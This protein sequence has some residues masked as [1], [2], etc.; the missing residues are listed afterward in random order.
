MIKNI[1]IVG[2]MGHVGFATALGLSKKYNVIGCYN[3]NINKKKQKLLKKNN[4]EI[5]KINLKNKKKISQFLKRR[6]I[7]KII[8]CAGVS[9][10]IYAKKDPSKTIES[11]VSNV[12]NIFEILKKIKK[13]QFLYI[14]TGSVFQ[15]IKSE[16]I[17]IYEDTVP[18]P[19][20]IYSGSKRMGEIIVESYRKYFRV[21]CSILRISW[22]YGPEEIPKKLNIQRGPIPFIINRIL[23]KKGKTINIATGGQFKASFTYIE[24][25]VSAIASI[26][27]NKTSEESIYHLGSGFNY[28]NYYLV[29]KI[30]KILNKKINIGKGFNPWSSDSVIR[31]PLIGKNL[32]KEYD[33]KIKFNLEKGLKTLLKN[34][35]K[36][37]S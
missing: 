36:Y 15:D 29:K 37:N 18:T 27:S 31:G 16:K 21:N 2:I 28:I 5:I 11:N 32:K 34:Y 33:F 3:L 24:D 20:S 25:V 7:L 30:G 22:V 26:I 13:I 14:S 12:I 35:E 8:Y 6:K 17:K 23:K 19:K 1:L 9:H 4:I 10:E